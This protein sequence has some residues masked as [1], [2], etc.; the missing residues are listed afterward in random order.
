[1]QPGNHVTWQRR[2]GLGHLLRQWALTL[3]MKVTHCG[4]AHLS[5]LGGLLPAPALF[6]TPPPPLPSLMV[7]AQGVEAFM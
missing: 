2:L 7:Y 4:D 6:C 5:S 3:R 1:M